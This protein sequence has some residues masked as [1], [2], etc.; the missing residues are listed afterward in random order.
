VNRFTSVA[1][2]NASTGAL[3]TVFTTQ[4][5]VESPN[6]ITVIAGNE[7]VAENGQLL[8][9]I[10]SGSDHQVVP[11]QYF[12]NAI[13][14][15]AD[16]ARIWISNHN[17]VDEFNIRN[18]ATPN[19]VTWGNQPVNYQ[20]GALAVANGNLWVVNNARGL[21]AVDVFNTTSGAHQS[22]Y[23]ASALQLTNPVAMT[24]SGGNLWIANDPLV[25]PYGKVSGYSSI[26]EVN[27]A[28][29]KLVKIV[30]GS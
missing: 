27:M 19:S 5:D 12:G 1:E 16:G 24:T 21:I 30:K 9:I 15:T 14:V 20:P 10:G 26:N 4:N 11:A 23:S 17:E 7:W 22:E 25:P 13:A 28:T 8:E 2:I 6:F 3:V 29:G 18:G